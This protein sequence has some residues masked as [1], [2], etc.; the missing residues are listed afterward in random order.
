MRLFDHSDIFP[1][2]KDESVTFPGFLAL[3]LRT[4]LR[5]VM[6]NPNAGNIN[7][8]TAFYFFKQL[9]DL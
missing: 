4:N 3:E 5:Y 6:K 7:T 8:G 9:M 2:E 1:L